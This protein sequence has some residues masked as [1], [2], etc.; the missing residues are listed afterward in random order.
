MR[1]SSSL[2]FVRK[3][4]RE[5][6]KSTISLITTVPPTGFRTLRFRADLFKKMLNIRRI[7]G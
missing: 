3:R 6:E 7:S 2:R 5:L 4:F 1:L